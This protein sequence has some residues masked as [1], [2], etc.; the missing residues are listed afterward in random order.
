MKKKVLGI[1]QPVFLPWTGYFEQMAYVDQFIF[2]DDVQYTRHDWRNRNKIRVANGLV[3]LTVPV[4]KHDRDC[5]IKDIKINYQKN[6]I[7]KHIKTIEL[8]YKKRPYFM[9]FF[10]DLSEILESRPPNLCELDV[11][12]IKLIAE[13]LEI[14]TP[15]DFSSNVPRNGNETQINEHSEGSSSEQSK[16]QRIVEICKYFKAD[17]LY[18]GKRAEEFIDK[19]YFKENGI[20]VIFQ[21]YI[22]PSYRQAFDGFIPYQSVI[23]LIMNE[24]PDAPKILRT[25]PV[26]ETLNA[27][28]RIK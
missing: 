24:G 19:D 2:M 9:P 3:W 20:E 15:T 16:N 5:S 14:V 23:D 26:P 17:I 10:K 22:H 18:D 7:R 12:L 4:K 13:Y 27:D 21:N 25:S 1:L 6:W 8:S 28:I 11:R